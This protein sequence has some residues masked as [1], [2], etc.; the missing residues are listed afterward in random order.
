MYTLHWERSILVLQIS[1]AQQTYRKCTF[2]PQHSICPGSRTNGLKADLV[3]SWKSC[4]VS[5]WRCWNISG[6]FCC[7]VRYS[8]LQWSSLPSKIVQ[9]LPP[10]APTST[11]SELVTLVPRQTSCDTN[12]HLLGVLGG[13][14]STAWTRAF[15]CST[16]TFH[17]VLRSLVDIVKRF[18]TTLKY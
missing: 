3:P 5:C 11:V 13:K 7:K 16:L 12:D 6:L 4:S 17:Q 8:P 15:S 1:P 14:L 9:L 18:L 2:L 10:P